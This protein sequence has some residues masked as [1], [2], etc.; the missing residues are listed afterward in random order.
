MRSLF[1]A[2]AGS[3]L[4][5]GCNSTASLPDPNE[6]EAQV[7][8]TAATEAL[9][10]L[11]LMYGMPGAPRNCQPG[12]MDGQEIRMCDVCAVHLIVNVANLGFD[13]TSLHL[14]RAEFNIPFRR[15]AS[16]DQPAV[17]PADP[18]QGVWVSALRPGQGA[19][20]REVAGRDLTPDDLQQVG[21]TMARSGIGDAPWAFSIQRPGYMGVIA[22]P[23]VLLQILAQSPADQTMLSLV[24]SCNGAPAA[25]SR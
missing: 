20:F 11:K 18:T 6:T 4:S 23:N 8:M 9:P 22:S 17:A 1:V 3:L 16:L 24:G 21:I 15:A 5:G 10:G 19:P 25:T 7:A 12:T 2:M 13:I 14:Q